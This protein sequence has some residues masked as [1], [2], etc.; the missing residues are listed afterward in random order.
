[1]RALARGLPVLIFAGALAAF[2]PALG[3]GFLNWDDAENFLGNPHYRGL[4]PAE[5]RWMLT[6]VHMGHYIPVTWLTLGLDHVLWGMNPA[7]YHLTSLVF[8]AVNA[9]LV[10]A[11]ALR[12]LALGFAPIS[13][14][15]RLALRLGA[16]AAALLFALHP[17]RVE[18][19]AWVT[20]R[21]DVVSGCLALTSVL[22]YLAAARRAGPSGRAHAGWL[23]A[24]AGAFLLA[25]FA[26]SIVVG[27][28]VVLL[29]LD[30]YPL[31]RLSRRTLV[32]VLMEKIPFVAAAAAAAGTMLAIAF[33]WGILAPVEAAS[34]PQ[35]LALTGYGLA[36]YLGKTLWPWPLSPLYTLYHPVEPLT[37]RY[38]VPAVIVIALTCALI[39]LRRRWPAG[40]TAW[41]AYVA[42]LL[43]AAGILPNGPQIAADRYS[44]LPLIGGAIVAGAGLPWGWR[45]W[46]SGRLTLPLARG[47]LAATAVLLI[48]LAV[49]THRQIAV[50]HDSVA[51]WRHAAWA[52]PD[53]DVPL[54]Y[55]GWA[56]AEGRRF[57]EARAHFEASLAR[58]PAS[59]PVL[60]AQFLVHLGI[61]EQQA[62]RSPEAERRLREAL[63]LDPDHPVAWIR[64]G[65][66][67]HARGARGEAAAALAAA[68][69]RAP[70]W[71]RYHV[72]ELRLAIAEVPEELADARAHLVFPLAV[73]L[74]QYRA[75]LEAEELY[76][77]AVR[78]DP[79]FAAAWNNL[80]AAQAE[81]G[82]YAEAME[83]FVRALR[84]VPRATDACANAR[85]AAAALGVRPVELDGCPPERS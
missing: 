37:A 5:V 3:G 68:S 61:V 27:L 10:Y 14:D 32:P 63:A 8:H 58:V 39:A 75:H 73:L 28:P 35:R 24:A 9:V 36:F 13:D 30:V 25:A 69:E 48:G 21:R 59:L 33:K 1:M 41:I 74:Q 42:L 71:S 19:V 43:P 7:G 72:W 81:R 57:D 54:F 56:L 23:A 60:R 17:L 76:G 46:R 79:Q 31:R 83:A 2:L 26:K 51:L 11:L 50:W 62:G 40:L 65:T 55:L 18:S 12:L 80:G 29:A 45:A 84:L 78:L 85:R 47:A 4:G 77:L 82:R 15:D 53:S 66:L 38:V 20:E 49:L 22:A 67:L 44:Y 70:A 6:A 34:I 64:L 16:A 52:D